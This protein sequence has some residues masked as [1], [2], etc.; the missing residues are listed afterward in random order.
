MPQYYRASERRIDPR[1]SSR[2][3][4]AHTANRLLTQK[5]SNDLNRFF[6]LNIEHNV[7]G[8]ILH[9]FCPQSFKLRKARGERCTAGGKDCQA[10]DRL[11]GAFEKT[12]RRVDTSIGNVHCVLLDIF[13]CLWTTKDFF[14]T[15]H[16]PNAF[17]TTRLGL[18]RSCLGMD[19]ALAGGCPTTWILHRSAASSLESRLV[20]FFPFAELKAW[21]NCYSS[22]SPSPWCFCLRVVLIEGR[23]V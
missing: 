11:L 7:V 23:F 20:L 10:F 9:Q 13:S 3:Y 8:E 2:F 12:Q 22:C 14:Q 17:D 5:C 19:T 1:Q 18:T 15:T 4:I 21:Y 6:S 16:L